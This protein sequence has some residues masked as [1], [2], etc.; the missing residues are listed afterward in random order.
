MENKPAGE[1]ILLYVLILTFLIAIG[2]TNDFVSDVHAVP[3]SYLLLTS[4]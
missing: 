4:T 3:Q 1:V 2:N